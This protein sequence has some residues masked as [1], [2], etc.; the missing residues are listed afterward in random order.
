M[1]FAGISDHDLLFSKPAEVLEERLEG[2]CSVHA[3]GYRSGG[4]P[5]QGLL[6]S[7]CEGD[8]WR[9]NIVSCIAKQSPSLLL[10]KI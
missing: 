6:L 8:C 2:P 9:I 1:P 4:S 3:P 10:C 5:S 7:C